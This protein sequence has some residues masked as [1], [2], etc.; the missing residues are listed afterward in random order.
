MNEE[1]IE[2]DF[3]NASFMERNITFIFGKDVCVF[4]LCA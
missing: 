2:N 4:T 3:F 1:D